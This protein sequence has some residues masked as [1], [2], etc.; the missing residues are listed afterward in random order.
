M[1]NSLYHK[2]IV[3]LIVFYLIPMLL[4]TYFLILYVQKEHVAEI[5]QTNMIVSKQYEINANN[6]IEIVE[7]ISESIN[8]N[9]QLKLLLGSGYAYKTNFNTYF[10]NIS[11]FVRGIG[12]VYN[13]NIRVYT[14][15]ED[16]PLGFGTFYKLSYISESKVIAE[17]INSTER[18]MWITEN[19]LRVSKNDYFYFPTED[20]Y[21]FI[22]KIM[23]HNNEMIGLTVISVPESNFTLESPDI[24][25]YKQGSS[26]II[27]LDKT[28]TENDIQNV[29]DGKFDGLNV[30][31]ESIKDIGVEIVFVGKE[32]IYV[33]K[34]YFFIIVVALFFVASFLYFI[35]YLKGLVND[36]QSYIQSTADSMENKY[37]VRL[38]EDGE[39]EL[40]LIA[41]SINNLLEKTETLMKENAQKEI[42]TKEANLIA[43]QYQ[44]NPHFIY[45]TLEIFS[46]KMELNGNYEESDAMTAFGN[47]FRYNTKTD[48][49]FVTVRE[50]LEQAE[51][52]ISIQKIRYSN[53]E[54]SVL[55]NPEMYDIQIIRFIFQPLIENCISHGIEKY[56]EEG[57]LKIQ[58]TANYTDDGKYITFYVCDYGVGM[59]ADRLDYVRNEI[60]KDT[61]IKDVKV[62]STG[63]NIGL[64]NI[65]LRLKLF[66]GEE[67]GLK[68]ESELGE[69]TVISFKIEVR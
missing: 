21:V 56:D 46:A 11:Q 50:E 64:Q 68:I 40:A 44:I 66:Y 14:V 19:D 16:I 62:V 12:G 7:N 51:N 25:V 27:P 42:A 20:R 2:L 18:R 52:Y 58:I 47:I 48:H 61:D 41:K 43:L 28:V 15:N 33:D 63:K 32:N 57:I 31:R 49:I 67:S 45:N 60:L 22:E 54:L 23:S 29:I 34:L 3:R 65:N 59:D 69:W 24:K 55:I 36:M 1:H 9:E 35:K 39:Y 6:N 26:R 17:F 13:A 30:F 4:I 8:T 5:E 37:S 10:N 38:D 53:I